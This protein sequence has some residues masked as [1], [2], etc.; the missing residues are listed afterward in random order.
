V[1]GFSEG[2][3]DIPCNATFSFRHRWLAGTTLGSGVEDDLLVEDG[4]WHNYQVVF[5]PFATGTPGSDNMIRV[6]LEEF[7]GQVGDAMFDNIQLRLL[8][9]PPTAIAGP[10]QTVA[11]GAATG[12][13]ASAS[14]DSD[15]TIVSYTWDFGDGTSYTETAGNAPDGA[16][17]GKTTHLY[18][19][20]G[21][22]TVTLTVADDDG[23]TV[24]ATQTVAVQNVAPIVEAGPDHSL[25]LGQ[26]L[27][28]AA[29]FDDPSRV[30]G[31]TYTASIDWGDGIITEGTVDVAAGSVTASHGYSSAGFF[32]V[33]VTVTDNGDPAPGQP[34]D[35]KSGSDSFQVTVI[36]PV[37]IDIKPGSDPNTTNLANE[38]LIAVAISTT[39]EFDASRVNASTVLFAGA[40][41]VQS[42]LEDVDGD[43]DL[44][45][46]L[47]F[48]TQDTNL[49][50][51]YEQLLADDLNGDG[52]LDSNQQEVQA[53]MTSKTLEELLFEG[54][55]TMDLFLAGR[56]LR[57]LLDA[58]AASG[59]I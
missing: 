19:D 13:D 41:A 47:Q 48:R 55:D 57:E 52:I 46:I 40:S 53:T 32:T 34:A 45:M 2:N 10:G 58:L 30:L 27:F 21:T 20:N 7:S 44:D 22:Y 54:A 38:G 18:A 51:I 39:A 35:P 23:T 14:S 36:L 29:S 9:Q 24:S 11:S 33:V 1:I 28:V 49:R 43:G 15:G 3:L 4:Q 31:E 12:F 37:R 26:T 6:M 42:A 17:D 8:N 25:I 59:A 5:D 50:A 56:A 16:F